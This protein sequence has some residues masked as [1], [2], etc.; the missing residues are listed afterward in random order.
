M[1]DK[2]FAVTYYDEQGE[3]HSHYVM[4]ENKMDAMDIFDQRTNGKYII[5]TVRETYQGN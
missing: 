2:E 3:I 1:K 4:G 5:E